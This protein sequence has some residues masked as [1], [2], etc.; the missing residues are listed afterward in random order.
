MKTI[1]AATGKA[2]RMNTCEKW[3]LCFF[4]LNGYSKKPYPQVKLL[5]FSV[6]NIFNAS[7][8]SFRRLKGMFLLTQ[9]NIVL[10]GTLHW[11]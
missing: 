10:S 9:D 3:R 5:C 1:T 7:I 8:Y 6:V 4:S 2:S 11:G